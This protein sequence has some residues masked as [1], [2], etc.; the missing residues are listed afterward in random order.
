MQDLE[1]SVAKLC[2]T[3]KYETDATNEKI[4]NF[5]LK[6]QMLTMPIFSWYLECDK[7][8]AEKILERIEIKSNNK[9]I[10][11]VR[12]GMKFFKKA[13]CIFEPNLMF[14]LKF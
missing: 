6:L 10:F 14:R 9:N 4:S 5:Y 1:N 8:T 2:D 13:N 3:A 11:M 7:S 12:Y